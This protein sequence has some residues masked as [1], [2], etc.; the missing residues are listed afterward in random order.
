MRCQMM[1][2]TR[3]LSPSERASVDVK[4]RERHPRV[5]PH[6]YNHSSP[7]SPRVRSSIGGPG[8]QR[9]SCCS[10]DRAALAAAW[11]RA[12]EQGCEATD[13]LPL[14]RC[15]W[16]CSYGCQNW[17]PLTKAS[18]SCL[19]CETARPLRTAEAAA[20][21]KKCKCV[22]YCVILISRSR[23]IIHHVPECA[24]EGPARHCRVCIW[25]ATWPLRT[26]L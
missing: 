4:A 8:R 7:G 17:M 12:A 23:R 14:R 3:S 15:C 20:E 26:A 22:L 10:P 18:P 16:R 1:M 2:R 6:F 13:D 19:P 25:A 24:I 21:S 9:N 5:I 11:Q